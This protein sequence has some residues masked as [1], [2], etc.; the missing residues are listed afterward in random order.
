MLVSGFP[1]NVFFSST[2]VGDVSA[3]MGRRRGE[4]CL[5]H[6]FSIYIIFIFLCGWEYHVSTAVY[7][8]GVHPLNWV[9]HPLNCDFHPRKS[10]LSV[11]GVGLI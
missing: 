11:L 6:R 10:L 9:I 4:C 8:G 7:L 3:C 2:N 1:L 5:G